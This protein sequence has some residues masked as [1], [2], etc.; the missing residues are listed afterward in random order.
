MSS[1]DLLSGFTCIAPTTI[2]WTV[3]PR[4]V[5]M[6]IYN[7]YNFSK[8]ITKNKKLNNHLEKCRNS[9]DNN[10][11]D[12]PVLNCHR[13]LKEKRNPDFIPWYNTM[14]NTGDYKF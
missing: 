2:V 10:T 13:K 9:I 4:D 6:I 5:R 14:V 3:N 8:L 7:L 12:Y 1:E 11:K